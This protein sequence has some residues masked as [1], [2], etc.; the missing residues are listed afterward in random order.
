MING[1][2]TQWLEE[3]RQLWLQWVDEF[4]QHRQSVLA[5][6]TAIRAA[7]PM[8]EWIRIAVVALVTAVITSQVTLAELK[9][10]IKSI[11]T[12]REIL[13]SKRSEQLAVSERRRDEQV[14][15]IK[16]HVE[17][18]EAAVTMIQVQ[19]AARKK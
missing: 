14:N 19:L 2:L 12:E 15:E 1:H 11:R 5:A 18:M 10:E 9:G 8:T 3:A 13:V 4:Q 17:R 16:R 6:A 7:L